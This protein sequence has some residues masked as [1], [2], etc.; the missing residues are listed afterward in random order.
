MSYEKLLPNLSLAEN[1]ISF[2]HCSWG[3][4][5]DETSF[6]FLGLEHVTQTLWLNKPCPPPLRGRS[7]G[8]VEAGSVAR[9]IP[10]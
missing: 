2:L 1:F 10:Q 9:D 6:V 7:K 3:S 5:W 4:G 8:L